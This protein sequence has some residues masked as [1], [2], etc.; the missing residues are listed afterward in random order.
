MKEFVIKVAAFALIIFAIF[1]S[2]NV[3][4]DPYN[5]FHYEYPIN[6][7]VE[8]NKNYIKTQYLLHHK[9]EFDS[10]IF[11][12]SRAGFLDPETFTDGKYY[13]MCSSE[14]LPA[15]HLHILK[16][17]IKK[18][19]VPKNVY[20]M[21]D[22]ISCFV[23]PNVDFHKDQLYRLLYPSD[24]IQSKIDFYSR[25]CDLITTYES[26]SVMRGFVNDDPVYTERYRAKGCE[27]LDK[28][29]DQVQSDFSVGYWADYY[30]L[31]LD[32]VISEMTDIVNL[33]NENGIKLTVVTNPLY[34]KTYG[35][36][37]EAG[38]LEF[39]EALAYVTPYWNFSGY[40]DIT[41]DENNY[42]ETSHFVPQVASKMVRTVYGETDDNLWKQGF[43]LYVTPDNVDEFI[44]FMKYQAEEY[45]GL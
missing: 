11:G 38:Y 24:G 9:D 36:D 45:E 40:S 41:T 7:G 43:G 42:Y 1:A 6:N 20:I 29:A 12:S 8:A 44:T 22:D 34:C 3:F 30:S 37:L 21:V 13:N 35:R 39:L 10:L 17:L 16:T 25:Y 28:T 27:R 32:G 33:C 19:F 18:G 4:I 15:E 5:I 2:I 26:L 14:A 31:R 23:D